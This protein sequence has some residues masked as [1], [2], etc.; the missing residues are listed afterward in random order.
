MTPDRVRNQHSRRRQA[1]RCR[2][3]PPRATSGHLGPPWDTDLGCS[4]TLSTSTSGA[5]APPGPV[6]TSHASGVLGGLPRPTSLPRC[7]RPRPVQRPRHQL[8]DPELWLHLDGPATAGPAVP[9][10]TGLAASGVP[11]TVRDTDG[12]TSPGGAPSPTPTLTAQGPEARDK[13]RG[14]ER[15]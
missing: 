14:S 2:G 5:P 6:P 1:S 9:V 4:L 13:G 3:R 15:D 7:T 12:V 11:A 10:L 8:S